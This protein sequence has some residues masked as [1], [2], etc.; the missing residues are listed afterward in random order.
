MTE[1]IFFNV[2]RTDSRE[3]QAALLAEMR[4]E[5]RVLAAKPG[6]LGMTVWVGLDANHRVLVEGRWAS[7]AHFHAAVGES[8]QATATRARLEELGKGEPGLFTESFELGSQVS[9]ATTAAESAV[10]QWRDRA[11]L[12]AAVNTPEAKAGHQAMRTHGTPDGTVYE[13]SDVFLP[14]PAASLFEKVSS[15]WAALG[16]ES[17][18]ITVNGVDLHV[19][20]GGEGSP[21]VLLHGYPQSGEIWRFV[22]P[23]LAKKHRVII[24]DLRGMGLSAIANNGFDLPNVADDMHQL[25]TKLGPTEVAVAGHD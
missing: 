22:A 6:F 13:V 1:T 11:S 4:S 18:T 14:N 19:V 7:R 24:P 23:E 10:A 3:R 5:A 16:F 12:E 2:W 9:E 20:S 8:S 15:R 25:I 17:T 21:L